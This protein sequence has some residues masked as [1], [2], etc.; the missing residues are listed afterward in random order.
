MTTVAGTKINKLLQKLPSGALF[1]SSWL[2]ENG[3]SYDLQRWYRDSSW[4]TSIGI[5]VMIR[6]GET[7]TIYDAVSCFNK[8]MGKQ[9]YFGAMS[10]LE[11]VG[12]THYVPMGR[13]VFVVCHPKEEKMPVWLKSRDWGVDILSVSSEYFDHNTGLTAIMQGAFEILVSSPERAFLE[14]L[15]LTPK[16]YNLMD[17]YYVMEQLTSLRPDVVQ[18]L[19]ENNKSVKVKRLFLYMAEKVG[20]VWFEDLNTSKISLGSGNRVITPNGVYDDKYQIV[21]PDELKDYE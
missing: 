19:L 15:N 10:A 9:F 7:P 12:Y 18:T 13:P 6:T 14:C 16:Y 20:H 21:I 17:L 3:I 8:Q 11:L 5:G 2:I 1:F 4:L